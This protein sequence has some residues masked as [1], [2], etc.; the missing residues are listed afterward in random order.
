[1]PRFS[2][3]QSNLHRLFKVSFR[4]LTALPVFQ[5]QFP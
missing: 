2:Y 4:S 3:F 1:M 5:T